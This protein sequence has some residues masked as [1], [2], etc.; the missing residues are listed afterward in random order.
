MIEQSLQR[1]ER[2]LFT[3]PVSSDGEAAIRAKETEM[4][5]AFTERARKSS[6]WAR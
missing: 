1:L 4:I 6:H 5:L 3:A 2:T